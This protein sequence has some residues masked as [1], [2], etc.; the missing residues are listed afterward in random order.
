MKLL[1]EFL[2]RYDKKKTHFDANH[3]FTVLWRFENLDA[4]AADLKNAI[5]ATLP[6]ALAPGL[7]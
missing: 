4:A 7:N 2:N 3:L 6:D 5:R 1:D